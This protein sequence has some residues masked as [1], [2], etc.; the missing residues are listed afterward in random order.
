M[1]IMKFFFTSSLIT[2]LLTI[3]VIH[4]GYASEGLYLIG[5]G[6]QL[7]GTAGAGD[8]RIRHPIDPQNGPC[9]RVPEANGAQDPER[10]PTG[11]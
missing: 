10:A 2:I 11:G 5:T 6:P 9:M 8:S 7:R 4:Q 3:I 1:R